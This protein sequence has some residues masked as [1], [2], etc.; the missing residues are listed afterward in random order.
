[1]MDTRP[2][3]AAIFM[4]REKRYQTRILFEGNESPIEYFKTSDKIGT[5]HSM[6]MKD[7]PNV[8]LKTT[9]EFDYEI[10]HI[11]LFGCRSDSGM[12]FEPELDPEDRLTNEKIL[13]IIAEGERILDKFNEK[14]KELENEYDALFERNVE[15][16]DRKS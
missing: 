1:M 13:E 11:K 9:T 2:G 10:D 8:T 15:D 6:L 7:F 5:V 12:P 14:A 4:V 16:T 3:I